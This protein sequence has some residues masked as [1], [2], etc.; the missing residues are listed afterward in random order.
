MGCKEKTR[1]TILVPTV[2]KGMREEQQDTVET[3][4]STTVRGKPHFLKKEVESLILGTDAMEV[5]K[6]KDGVLVRGS[7]GGDVV[8]V[9]VVISVFYSGRVKSL[10]SVSEIVQVH[11]KGNVEINSKEE[12]NTFIM[13]AGDGPN[14]VDIVG[15]ELENDAVAHLE[16]G[17]F[18]IHNKKA[19]ITEAHT[20]V[21]GCTF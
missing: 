11:L 18:N 8:T 13:C 19:G 3:H 12:I 16:Q 2:E 21:H 5:L 1:E 7:V 17:R 20:W 15:K 4:P 14:T 6:V 10:S 9:T